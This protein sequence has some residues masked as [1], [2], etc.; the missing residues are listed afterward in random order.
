MRQLP[1]PPF[2]WLLAFASRLCFPQLF[3]L[4][5]AVFLVELIV[6][7]VIPFADEVVLGLLT[8]LLGSIESKKPES[9]TGE[10]KPGT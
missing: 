9:S 7:H 3:L 6:P 10:N 2:R 8:A 5:A 4:T 1:F